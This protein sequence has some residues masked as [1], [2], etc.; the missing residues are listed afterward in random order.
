MQITLCPLKLIQM[1]PNEWNPIYNIC[2]P[3]DSIV[4]DYRVVDS[5][6]IVFESIVIN[7]LLC[8]HTNLE[9]KENPVI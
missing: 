5:M 4:V 1:T 8:H 2:D 7:H 9:F 3:R 6:V